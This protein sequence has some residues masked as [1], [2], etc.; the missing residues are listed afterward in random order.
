MTCIECKWFD[1]IGTGN[2]WGKCKR[3]LPV[4]V[5]DGKSAFPQTLATEKNC[6]FMETET[7]PV[8]AVSNDTTTSGLRSKAKTNKK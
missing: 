5:R 2:N 7:T 8:K 4:I 1:S 3:C 6:Y